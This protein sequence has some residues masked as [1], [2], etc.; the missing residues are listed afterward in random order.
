MPINPRTG[1]NET[2][3]KFYKIPLVHQKGIGALKFN[4]QLT[5][6]HTV[7]L[8]GGITLDFYAKFGK[9]DELFVTF[10]GA[11][12]ADRHFYPR[13][14]RVSSMKNRVPALM[15]FADPT[16]LMD[17]SFE[18][19][20][21]WYL[22]GPGFDPAS[23]MLKAI[24]KAQGKTGAKHIAFV[25]GSG[26]GLIALRMAAMVP[27]SLAFVQDAATN[28]A[29]SIPRTVAHY[30]S[31]MWP[32]WD[33]EKLLQGLPE[34]FDMARHYGDFAPQN[35]VYYSQNA[36]DPL[37]REKHYTPFKEACGVKGIDGSNHDGSRQFVVYKGERPGHGQITSNE[38]DFHFDAALSGW[39]SYRA[40]KSTN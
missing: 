8:P 38:F 32:G 30:F 1:L 37:Y 19:R 5:A 4:G 13:F 25:G 16:L 26:G 7:P 33:Q 6:V 35:Y 20:L 24:R 28:I 12:T 31:T 27:G 22:G 36:D 39:R 40:S 2:T 10:M 21:S 29:N 17:P 14:S 34:R 9:S 15:A 11:N 18:M 23:A 3:D